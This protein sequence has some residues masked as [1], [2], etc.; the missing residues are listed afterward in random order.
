MK[1]IY[2]LANDVVFDQLI[3]L[4]NSIEINY[5][6]NIPVCVIP[7]DDRTLKV[8]KEIEKRDNVELFDN[9]SIL[10]E[11]K[12]FAIKVWKSN[13]LATK[14]WE[15]KGIFDFHRLGTHA[16][17][18]GFDDHS[19]F[20]EFIYCDADI[21]ILNSLDYIF[22]KLSEYDFVVYDFQH[23]DP[24]HV[25]NINSPQLFT[26]FPEER[27]KS[28]IFCSGFY[29]SKK[30]LFS[31]DFRKYTIQKIA[32]QDSEIIYPW[33]PDQTILNYMTMI[34][35]L[36]KY[37]FA[38]ELPP[39]EITGNAVT[40]PH[41]EYKNNLLYDKGIRLTYLHYIGIPASVFTRVCAGENLDFP[42]R[43]IFL[44]YRYLHE[45]EKMP[46]LVGKPKPYNPPPT[47]MDKV[48]R[49]LGVKTKK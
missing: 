2:T 4:L 43:D 3:A 23:K 37:N 19:I 39:E 35:D 1:G 40:S 46:K 26:V 10:D 7:Y 18:C 42:Y 22:E 44:H 14:T 41:F 9:K 12:D 28:D 30:G 31:Q 6:K 20:S 17:F 32:N 8:K 11:W 29:G 49:K 48:F 38:L 25:Y 21:L 24:S 15:K 13:P 36:Q 45:P 27:I 34:T 16:R 33:A 47:F 5:G